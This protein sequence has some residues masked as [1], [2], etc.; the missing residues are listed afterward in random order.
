MDIVMQ[1][2]LIKNSLE[3]CLGKD[4]PYIEVLSYKNNNKLFII[5]KD[6][7]VGMDKETL[8]KIKVPFYTTKANGTGLGVSLSKEIIEAHNGTLNY[9]SIK[10]KKTIAK[11][12][13]P[14]Q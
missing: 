1:E 2:N 12:I 8:D 5:I 7:G 9:T 11:I 6:N 3:A 13:L 14:I 10:D 4:N